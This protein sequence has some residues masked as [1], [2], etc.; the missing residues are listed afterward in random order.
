MRCIEIIVVVVVYCVREWININMRCIEIRER[1][2]RRQQRRE[3]N[4][5]MRC[6]EIYL[7]NQNQ[8]LYID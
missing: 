2:A 3:I 1:R 8:D 5:N 4:I 7:A 6:I